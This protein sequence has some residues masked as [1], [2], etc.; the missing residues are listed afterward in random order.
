MLAQAAVLDIPGNG[1]TLSGIG[2][3]SDWK[4]AATAIMVRIDDGDPIPMQHGSERG[5]TRGGCGDTA[6]GFLAIFN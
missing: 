4:C 2:V 5:D 1:S 3:I 6:N